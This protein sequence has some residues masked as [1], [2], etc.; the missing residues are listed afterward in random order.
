MVEYWIRK[1]FDDLCRVH[2]FVLLWY[3]DLS[4]DSHRWRNLDVKVESLLGYR[5]Q[6][7]FNIPCVSI[8]VYATVV[9]IPDRSPLFERKVDG[10]RHHFISSHPW[11]SRMKGVIQRCHFKRTWNTHFC[12]VDLLEF[13]LEMCAIC[14]II[15]SSTQ[16]QKARVI[17]LYLFFTWFDN[18]T[19]SHCKLFPNLQISVSPNLR[20]S[21][22][23]N[24]QISESRMK[25][26]VQSEP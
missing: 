25:H 4:W 21:E 22:S 26:G 16:S 13:F 7:T 3:S 11:E 20:I 17:F 23:S 5:L 18:T 24:L 8:N 14:S 2:I 1:N 19:S 9:K 6:A 15:W 10:W 12:F